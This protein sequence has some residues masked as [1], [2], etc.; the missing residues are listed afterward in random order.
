MNQKPLPIG[1]DNFKSLRSGTMDICLEMPM[2][3]TRGA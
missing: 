3:I 2:Y 1:I